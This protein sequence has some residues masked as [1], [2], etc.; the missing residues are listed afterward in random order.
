MHIYIT[1]QCIINFIDRNNI[2]STIQDK[3]K[4]NKSYNYY[5]GAKFS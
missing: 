1:E 2:A 3:L 4:I 5:N